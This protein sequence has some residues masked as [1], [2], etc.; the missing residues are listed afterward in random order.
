M[1]RIYGNFFSFHWLRLLG[2]SKV[3][4]FEC[5]HLL[6]ID[7]S[8]NISEHTFR[9]YWNFHFL[10]FCYCQMLI[11]WDCRKESWLISI[12]YC[13][14]S[15]LGLLTVAYSTSWIMSFLPL[16]HQKWWLPVFFIHSSYFKKL[17]QRSY[18]HEVL[19]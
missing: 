10:L 5:L 18:R 11:K 16:I 12:D 7:L 1:H 14:I 13:S 6:L 9:T 19:L 8:R 3:D 4:S 17:S 15:C 2:S